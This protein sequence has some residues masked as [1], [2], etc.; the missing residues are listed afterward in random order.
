MLKRLSF[1][2][3]VTLFATFAT[4]QTPI[5]C[6]TSNSSINGAYGFTASEVP[7]SGVGINPPG[8]NTQAYSNT[9]IGNLISGV[10]GTNPFSASGILY[11]DGQGNIT[12]SLSSAVGGQIKVGTYTVNSDCTISVT[13]TDALNTTITGTNGTPPNFATTKLIGLVVG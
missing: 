12:A 11:F 6:Q 9:P 13:L 4:A 2:L 10:N 8:T 3:P 5:G 1:F 7:L